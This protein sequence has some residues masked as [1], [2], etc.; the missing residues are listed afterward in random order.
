MHHRV[1]ALG[2]V[3]QDR[4][5]R[6]YLRVVVILLRNCLAQVLDR[7]LQREQFLSTGQQYRVLEGV[8]QPLFMG[9]SNNL[10]CVD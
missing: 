6:Q 2:R 7:I 9:L 5:R 1:S 10:R 3:C 4:C 8:L